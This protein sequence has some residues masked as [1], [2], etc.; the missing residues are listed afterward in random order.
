MRSCTRGRERAGR[1]LERFGGGFLGV[2]RLAMAV[3]GTFSTAVVPAL[4]LVA[5]PSLSGG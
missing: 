2:R 3:R 4:P 1:F 5:V